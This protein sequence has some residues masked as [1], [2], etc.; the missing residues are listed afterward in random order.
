MGLTSWGSGLRARGC[1]LQQGAREAR[2][3]GRDSP[4][5]PGPLSTGHTCPGTPHHHQRCTRSY[6][7]EPPQGPALH[8]EAQG[9]TFRPEATSARPWPSSSF[10]K[11][12]RLLATPTGATKNSVR[13]EPGDLTD[14]DLWEERTQT[15]DRAGEALGPRRPGRSGPQAPPQSPAHLDSRVVSLQL[16]PQLG[17]ASREPHAGA[18]GRRTEDRA[19]ETPASARPEPYPPGL[20]PRRTRPPSPNW[21]TATRP[22]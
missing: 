8:R 11:R 16:L 10:S 20:R 22:G 9:R 4:S 13:D 2:V 15:A 12:W 3:Q 14:S 17:R 6:G 7:D 18:A 21:T 19:A 5:L 1:W